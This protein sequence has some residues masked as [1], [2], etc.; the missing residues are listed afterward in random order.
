MRYSDTAA[1]M[2]MGD[3]RQPPSAQGIFDTVK[4]GAART[5]TQWYWFTPELSPQSR[6]LQTLGWA[7]HCQSLNIDTS[8]DLKWKKLTHGDEHDM[9]PIS[10][11]SYRT[12]TRVPNPTYPE[13]TRY[14]TGSFLEF[15]FNDDPTHTIIIFTFLNVKTA[16][17]RDWGARPDQILPHALPHLQHPSD[18]MWHG[19]R[20]GYGIRM[21]FDRFCFIAVTDTMPLA[22]M[23][24]VL[25]QRSVVQME[26]WP[27]H[28]QHVSASTREGKALLGKF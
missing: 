27:A 1:G 26:A 21:Q 24:R 19:T 14:G 11:Q 13:G 12:G 2:L 16:A 17:F 5:L 9:I 15:A 7:G 20:I 10:L 28:N 3:T 6:D 23:A 22:I 4:R 8:T 25:M 18:L